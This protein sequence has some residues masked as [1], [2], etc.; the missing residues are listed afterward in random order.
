MN[1]DLDQ[2][3][4]SAVSDIVAAAPDVTDDPTVVL[5]TATSGATSRRLLPAAAAVLV[6]AAG[7]TV[8]ALASRGSP[9]QTG[10]APAEQPVGPALTD[11]EP[12]LAPETTADPDQPCRDG[13]G[14]TTVPNVAGIPYSEAVDTLGAAGVEFE[15]VPEGSPAEEVAIVDGYVVV[16]QHTAPG[17]TLVCGDVVVLTVGYRAR[18]TYTIQ[19]GDTWESIAAAQ[20]ISVED[21]LDFN[22]L[23]IAELEATSE[24]VASPLDVGRVI[25]FGVPVSNV[26]TA[27]PTT[28]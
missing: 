10:P 25:R 6:V 12:E 5:M 2:A 9:S 22:G 7:V 1:T 23:T 24:T 14:E 17:S 18:A 8:I 21:L 13:T 11:P 3:I 4:K 20:G 19:P 27:P 28:G 15:V 16:K 26:G